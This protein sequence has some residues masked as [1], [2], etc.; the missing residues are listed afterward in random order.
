ML[1][2][3]SLHPLPRGIKLLCDRHLQANL[4]LHRVFIKVIRNRTAVGLYRV[5]G[6]IG[7]NLCF[8]L[9]NTDAGG[10]LTC[11]IRDGDVRCVDAAGGGTAVV[12]AVGAVAD[13]L[14]DIADLTIATEVL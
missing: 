11:C 12:S 14:V 9:F 2:D 6:G 7:L 13:G 5:G 3:L 10:I 8:D 4:F 1:I